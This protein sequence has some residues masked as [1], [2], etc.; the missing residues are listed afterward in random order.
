MSDNCS[1]ES[2][3][4]LFR[5]P[6]G[7]LVV[8][9]DAA[10]RT[11][12]SLSRL[13]ADAR[14]AGADLVWAHGVAVD[15]SLG[16]RPRGGYVRLEAPDVP[17]PVD[18]AMPPRSLVQ[19]LHAECFAGVWGQHELDEPDP[20]AFYVALREAGRWVGLCEFDVEGRW[21]AGPG[22]VCGLR[23]PDRYARLV[24]G[25]AACMGA[26]PVVLETWGDGEE[27]LAAYR[28]LGFAVV[29]VVPGWEL[30]LQSES[31]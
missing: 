17:A 4:A 23:T 1:W 18:L 20:A 9:V 12:A 8:E 21:I 25:A 30:R 19:S 31:R 29:E 24:R 2:D 10:R 6:E 22:I 14:A 5:T 13:V 7:L 27:T 3:A 28:D 15:A 26:G 11:G 16:F